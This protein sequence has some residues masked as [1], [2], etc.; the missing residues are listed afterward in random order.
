MW[1]WKLKTIY[2]QLWTEAAISFGCSPFDFFA[3]AYYITLGLLNFS[4]GLP[5]YL[6]I[7]FVACKLTSFSVWYL[8][9]KLL[10]EKVVNVWFRSLRVLHTYVLRNFKP[11]L[12]LKNWEKIEKKIRRKEKI[13]KYKKIFEVNKLFLYITLNSFHLS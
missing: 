11:C 6:A 1:N 10:P 7:S 9:N 12:V 5:F 13:K 4:S 3:S 2:V 8:I